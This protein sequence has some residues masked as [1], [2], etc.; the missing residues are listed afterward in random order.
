[1][2][3]EIQIFGL[4]DG[5]FENFKAENWAIISPWVAWSECR[6]RAMAQ[7]EFL[8]RENEKLRQQLNALGV[9][10]GLRR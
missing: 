4:S 1:M 10:T 5:A 2:K 8:E 7:I 9:D 6:M 3:T